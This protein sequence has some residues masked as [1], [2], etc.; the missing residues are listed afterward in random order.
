MSVCHC[1]AQL[2]HV[3]VEADVITFQIPTFNQMDVK[4]TLALV[5]QCDILY[6][7][8]YLWYKLLWYHGQI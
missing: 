1:T 8:I 7:H 5:P 4:E 2:D 6:C 3:D